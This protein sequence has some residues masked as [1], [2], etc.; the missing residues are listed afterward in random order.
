MNADKRG[1]G[2]TLKASVAGT[3]TFNPAPKGC[4]EATAPAT[5]KH[6]SVLANILHPL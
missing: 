6:N 3:P 4:A 5:R 2:K 1:S